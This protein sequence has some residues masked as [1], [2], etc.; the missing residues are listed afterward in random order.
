MQSIC[1]PAKV[2][3]IFRRSP[4]HS[5]LAGE[6]RGTAQDSG[7]SATLRLNQ[8]TLRLYAFAPKNRLGFGYVCL[9]LRSMTGEQ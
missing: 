9:A 1:G 6:R 5:R 3:P 7:C 2:I 8:P 4:S